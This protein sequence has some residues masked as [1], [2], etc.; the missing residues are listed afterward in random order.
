MGWGSTLMQMPH[1]VNVNNSFAHP[2]GGQKHTRAHSRAAR[3]CTGLPTHT[4]M[5]PTMLQALPKAQAK[6]P[7]WLA[8]RSHPSW[9]PKLI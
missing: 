1:F 4:H 6:T 2:G 8:H 3:G 5:T 7:A 9:M